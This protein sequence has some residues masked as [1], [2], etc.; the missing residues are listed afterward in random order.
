MNV[1][2]L[3]FGEFAT[4]ERQKSTLGN[5]TKWSSGG[6]PSKENPNFWEGDIP[7]ISASTMRGLYYSDSDV[8][9]TVKLSQM[10]E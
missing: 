9:R 8:N 6:T 4:E 5:L 3:R 7:W 1:P 10:T 2:K